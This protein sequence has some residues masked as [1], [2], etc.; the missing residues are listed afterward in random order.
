MRYPVTPTLSVDAAHVKLAAVS[1]TDPATTTGLPGTVG[2]V[3]SAGGVLIVTDAGG[4]ESVDCCPMASTART[5][6]VMV[7]VPGDESV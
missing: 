3:V 6:Y 7:P 2:A 1:V 5:V 4:S